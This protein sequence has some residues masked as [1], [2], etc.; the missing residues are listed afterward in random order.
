MTSNVIQFPRLKRNSPPQT[1]E[2]LNKN[3]EETRKEHIEYI[4]DESMS[5]AFQKAFDEGFDLGQDECF[6]TTAMLIETY[7]AA[8]C[9]TVGIYHPLHDFADT[10]FTIADEEDEP[11]NDT[12]VDIVNESE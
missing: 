1:L 2:E 10:A 12:S 3:I 5:F 6:K 4:I 11:V 7:R 8:L 9:R